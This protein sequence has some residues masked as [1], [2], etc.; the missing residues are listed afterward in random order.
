MKMVLSVLPVSLSDV[1]GVLPEVGRVVHDPRELSAGLAFATGTG[2]G[3]AKGTKVGLA[4]GTKAGFAM[5]SKAALLT[6]AS[7]LA[8]TCCFPTSRAASFLASTLWPGGGIICGQG[9]IGGRGLETTMRARL[10]F[11]AVNC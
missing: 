8:N 7:A 10:A 1:L 3:L 2:L 5:D 6:G 4:M 9:I 11:Q